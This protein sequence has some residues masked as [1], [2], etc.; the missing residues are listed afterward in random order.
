M[1]SLL[2]RRHARRCLEIVNTG[3]PATGTFDP[4]IGVSRSR[5]AT[6]LFGDGSSESKTGTS[7]DF[8]H[9]YPADG[10]WRARLRGVP[11]REITSI[12]AKDDLV[13]EIRHLRRCVRLGVLEVPTN[14][15]LRASL[16]D[17][18][19]G[20]TYLYVGGCPLITGELSDVPAGLTLLYV[21]GCSLI[22]GDLSDVPAGVTYLS[23]GGCPLITGDLSDVPAGVTYL[24]VS[25]CALITGDLSDVPAGVTTLYAY[26]SPLISP[27]G[28]HL[29]TSISEIQIY[30]NG[31][32]SAI[33][34]AVLEEMYTHRMSFTAA[35][36]YLNIGG[37]N[38]APSGLYQDATP[39][40]TG[41]EFAF[42]LVVDPDGDGHKKW[43][44][45]WTGGS[46]P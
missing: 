30:S 17:V 31:Y 8:S 35:A 14:P 20:V 26:S 40:T 33:V 39:P 5:P 22:T 37:T 13:T 7:L 46:A 27:V 42:K 9:T 6:L 36:P 25:R 19:A 44:I 41:L 34:D 45:S 16:R 12:Y 3:G 4:T 2:L 11:L 28:I 43:A 21:S 15:S 10:V 38:A 29:L 1:I 18:P 32:S 23:V 24:Y